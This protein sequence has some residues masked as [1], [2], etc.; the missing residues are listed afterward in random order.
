M[1]D[2]ELSDSEDEGEGGRR[3]ERSMKGR[4]RPRL[5]AKGADDKALDDKARRDAPADAGVEVKA[6]PKGESLCARH[7]LP[8]LG[9]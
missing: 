5:D 2:N 3:N 8:H 4:K 1:P 9:N 7:Q 6:E